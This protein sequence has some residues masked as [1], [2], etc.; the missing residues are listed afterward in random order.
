M[1]R[2]RLSQRAK[3]D[4]RR[5]YRYGVFEFGERQADRYYVEFLNRF[6]QIATQPYLYPAVDLTREGYRRSVSGSHSIYYRVEIDI[7][8][9]IRILGR[10]DTRDAL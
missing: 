9:I 10:Q 5:I 2:Y 7:V 3:Q 4:L 6:E 1:A 8:E